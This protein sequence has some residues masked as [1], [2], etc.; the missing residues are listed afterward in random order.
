MKTILV[1][2]TRWMLV[3]ILLALPSSPIS[4]DSSGERTDTSLP[5]QL[6]TIRFKDVS[7]VYLLIEPF[8]SPEGSVRMQ[9]RL[10]TLAVTDGEEALQKIEELI[11]EY[12]LPPKNVEVAMQLI[13][14]STTA[15]DEA[16]FS[17]RIRGVIKRLNEITTRWSDYHLLGS[18]TVVSSEGEK[19]SIQMG[20]NYRIKFA[21]DYAS[22]EQQ[23]IRF[24][25]FTLDR[26]KVSSDTNGLEESFSRVL[27]T[28]L[29]LKS[30]KLYIFGASR[31]E[32]S[33]RALFMTITASL[34]P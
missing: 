7:D 19:T 10:R 33:N 15:G 22:D 4:S 18:A 17:P 16:K 5:T 24:D 2:G 27:D 14:A 13:L 3:A 20:E 23:L 26:R 25:R 12:D 1:M 32:N 28:S 6:F 34:Q 9:P 31:L 11:G 29:N 8:L 30:D 21:V